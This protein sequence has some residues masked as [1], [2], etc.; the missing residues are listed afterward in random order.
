MSRALTSFF[1]AAE[2][3]RSTGTD[4]DLHKP[5]LDAVSPCRH[6]YLSS[7]RATHYPPRALLVT[8]S[9]SL[10]SHEQRHHD[11][12]RPDQRLCP[13]VSSFLL[14]ITKSRTPTS[15]ID[16]F[17]IRQFTLIAMENTSAVRRRRTSVKRLHKQA[18]LRKPDWWTYLPRLRRGDRRLASALALRAVLAVAPWSVLN[19]I[20]CCDETAR[21]DPP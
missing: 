20:Q 8:T 9:T 14:I 17:N 1:L 12:H 21:P 6:A 10:P 4:V 16:G 7:V 11:I 2:S 19:L 18:C 13:S 5:L 3:K 15:F